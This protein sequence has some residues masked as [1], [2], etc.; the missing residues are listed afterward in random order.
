MLGE[1]GKVPCDVTILPSLIQGYHD[2][3]N[4]YV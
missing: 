2:L 1:R 4:L 3:A